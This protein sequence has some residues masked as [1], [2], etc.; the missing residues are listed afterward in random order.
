MFH[1]T[2]TIVIKVRLFYASFVTGL[3]CRDATGSET[4]IEPMP[5]TEYADE[6]KFCN[7]YVAVIVAL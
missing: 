5:L 2:D 1:Q 3:H 4:V 7:I 6:L